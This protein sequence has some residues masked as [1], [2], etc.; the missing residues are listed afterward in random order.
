VCA[1]EAMLS[2]T[3][4][5]SS[6]FND[7]S[8]TSPSKPSSPAGVQQPMKTTRCKGASTSS[9]AQSTHLE[10]Q[11]PLQARPTPQL[12]PSLAAASSAPRAPFEP[13][14]R[15]RPPPPAGRYHGSRTGSTVRPRSSSSRRDR[16]GTAQ[17]GTVGRSAHT[18]FRMDTVP[19]RMREHASLSRIPC[20]ARHGTAG[21][22]ASA[23][24]YRMFG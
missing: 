8:S 18:R 7:G 4:A 12:P 24:R 15:A 2:S 17:H 6:S 22:R 5:G 21:R 9:R 1:S 10:V 19:R 16:P 23:A 3:A 14:S 20:Y 11:S 13:A